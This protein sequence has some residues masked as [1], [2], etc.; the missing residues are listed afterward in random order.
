MALIPESAYNLF[1]ASWE[2]LYLVPAGVPAGLPNQLFSRHP[3][4]LILFENLYCDENGLKGEQNAAEQ[5]KWTNS[6]LF[7]R[8]AS[9]KYDI[10]KPLNLKVQLHADVAEIKRSFK[11]LHDGMSINKAIAAESVSV[12]ELFEWRLQLLKGF[13]DREKLVLYCYGPR[14]LIVIRPVTSE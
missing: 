7:V 4:A 11:V 9:S 13:L 1:L 2:H 10:I 12:D 6:E 14:S 8:L 3:W 5:M